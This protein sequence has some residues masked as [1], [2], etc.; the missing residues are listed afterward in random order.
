MYREQLF[1]PSDAFIG[2]QV[3]TPAAVVFEAS[4][5][6]NKEKDITCDDDKEKVKC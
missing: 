5:I 4:N 2:F 6:L 1:K 3:D